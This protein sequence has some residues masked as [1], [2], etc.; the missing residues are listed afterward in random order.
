MGEEARGN[1]CTYRFS[2]TYSAAQASD[3]R[4][5]SPYRTMDVERVDCGLMCVVAASKGDERQ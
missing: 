3:E 1:R 2:L 5:S 4:R